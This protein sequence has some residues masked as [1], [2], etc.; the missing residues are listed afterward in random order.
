M[1]F[2]MSTVLEKQVGRCVCCGALSASI[3]AGVCEGVCLCL[4][5]FDVMHTMESL[6]GPLWEAGMQGLQNFP[7]KCV[8]GQ[9]YAAF[10]LVVLTRQGYGRQCV[11][12]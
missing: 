5:M 2:S 8:A 11:C 12:V 7:W 3:S 9:Q 10:V 4:T 1:A 6:R